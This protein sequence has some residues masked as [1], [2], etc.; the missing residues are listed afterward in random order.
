MKRFFLVGSFMLILFGTIQAKKT[1]SEFNIVFIGN[2][3]THGAG[4][5]DPINQAPPA[6]TVNYLNKRHYKV[7]FINCGVS[8]STTVDI[9][10]VS[11]NLFPQII[12]AADS[13]SK[14]GLPLLFS[15]MIGTNDSAIKGPTGSPVSPDNYRKNVLAI[16]DSLLNRYPG[17]HVILNRPIWYSPNTH[18]GALYLAE[19]LARL[20]RYTPEILSIVQLRK[21]KVFLGDTKAFNFFKQNY[22]QYLSPEKGNSGTFYLH[23]NAL[24]AEKLGEFW[25]EALIHQLKRIKD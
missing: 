9:L 1:V 3:I 17:S 20:Q 25:G 21:G 8:G 2:S 19:G 11:K 6:R 14:T 22:L 15:I 10:P 5:Q 13:L 23:P 18:N 7:N 16:I 12:L 24:G 4:L